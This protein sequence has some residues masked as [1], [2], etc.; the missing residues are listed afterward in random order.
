[1]SY[2]FWNSF[3]WTSNCY[4]I[5]F[6]HIL[7]GIELKPI[8]YYNN[9][10]IKNENVTDGYYSPK[11]VLKCY[12]AYGDLIYC[13]SN[14]KVIHSWIYMHQLLTINE[15]K[16]VEEKVRFRNVDTK[17]IYK[18]CNKNVCKLNGTRDKGKSSK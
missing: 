11:R 13:K 8:N 6:R 9:L 12:D 3:S 18:Y 10:W 2:C 15:K 14:I 1:M 5:K 4:C 17:E 16:S 7:N